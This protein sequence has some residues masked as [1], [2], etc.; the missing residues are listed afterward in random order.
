MVERAAERLR[1]VLRDAGKLER[2]AV[3]EHRVAAAV[4]HG[5]RMSGR[6][7]VEVGAGERPAVL[8]LGVVVE[9]ALDPLARA[10]VFAA[11]SLSLATIESMVTNSTSYGLPTRTS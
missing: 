10:A 8:H 1:R 6:H 4:D 7:A 3:D 9:E 11:R 5:D 2:L